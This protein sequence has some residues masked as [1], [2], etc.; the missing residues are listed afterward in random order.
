MV[1]DG[2]IELTE[3]DGAMRIRAIRST[4]GH[5]RVVVPD[6][7][8]TGQNLELIENGQIEA[9]RWAELL[10]G[11]DI[12]TALTSTIIAGETLTIRGDHENVDPGLGTT[13]D[14]QGAIGGS[15]AEITGESDDDVISLLNILEGT[16]TTVQTFNGDDT[17]NVGVTSFAEPSVDG[18]L[19]A[20]QGELWVDAGGGANMLNVTDRTNSYGR[21]EVVITN[22]RIAGFAPVPIHFSATGTFGRGINI[23][24]GAGDDGFQI[25]RT[26]SDSIT[27]IF[28]GAGD[29]GFVVGTLVPSVDG[30]LAMFGELGSDNVD[31]SASSL[32]VM[33]V[34]DHGY[35]LFHVD[36][37]NATALDEI[38]TV[39]AADGS[40]DR[41][42]GGSGNDILMGGEAGDTLSSGA[43]HDIVLGDLGIVK[44][45]SQSV[46]TEVETSSPGEG[47]D[48]DITVGNGLDVAFGGAGNDVIQAGQR[49]PNATD[50]FGGGVISVNFGSIF[51]GAEVRD[52]AG[53]VPA[54]NW[55]NIPT[56][57]LS[58]YGDDPGEAL[59]L[60]D[61][62]IAEG[63]TVEVGRDLDA[64]GPGV[65]GPLSV[66]SH[67]QINPV[68]DPNLRLF[69][70]YLFTDTLKTLGVNIAGL[71]AFTET[72]YDVYVYLDADEA[73]SS[74]STSV[75]RI[76]DGTTTYFLNDPQGNSFTG[77]FIPVD[78]T[79]P[80]SA[81][82][83]NYVVFRN[84]TSNAFALRID[85]QDVSNPANTWNRPAITALQ[86][87]DSTLDFE[88]QESDYRNVLVGDSGQATFAQG[89]LI[90]VITTDHPPQDDPLPQNDQI[91]GGEGPDIILGGNQ[92]DD[93][94]GRGGD[95]LILG[96]NARVALTYNSPSAVGD[97]VEID[98]LSW[99]NGGDDVLE[100]AAG[101]DRLYGQFGNDRYVFA[102]GQLGDDQVIEYGDG[103]GYPNDSH[104][105]LDFSEFDFPAIIDL[106]R[107]Q[108][109]IVALDN[110]HLTLIS[111]ATLEDVIGSPLADEILGNTRDNRLDGRGGN[112][113][114]KG[115]AGD[116]EIL[117]G[118]GDDIA[119]GGTGDDLLLGE[120]GDDTLAGEAGDDELHGGAG[121][122]QMSGGAGIDT[123]FGEFG[124][125][126]MDGGDDADALF[127]GPGDDVMFGGAGMDYAEGNEGDDHLHG[128]EEADIMFGGS[129]KDALFGGA[130]D[131]TLEGNEDDDILSGD[132]GM[133]T[134]L[135][136]SGNDLIEGG[137]ESD[138]LLGGPGNDTI[139]G[140]EGDDLI[141]GGTGDDSLRGDAG[142]DLLLGQEGR[143]T[144]RGN[145]G[146]DRIEGHA[147]DD[148]LE[149]NDGLD[150]IL[151]QDGHDVISGGADADFID[152][153]AGDDV[154]DGGEG[155]DQIVGNAGN[156]VLLGREGQD[157]LH[158]DAGHDEIDGG[159]GD[160]I[161]EG[162]DDSDVIRGGSGN[163][164]IRGGLGNDVIDGE[165]G[166][167]VIDGDEGD[168]VIT[169]GEGSDIIVG[170][171]GD[172]H[173]MLWATA[174]DSQTLIDG[175]DDNDT[176]TLG[177][178]TLNNF[179]GT[180][181]VDGGGGADRLELDDSTN[182]DETV[183][184]VTADSVSRNGLA[185]LVNYSAIETLTIAAGTQPDRFA[186]AASAETSYLLDGGQPTG[187]SGTTPG[188][189]LA[190]DLAGL[191]LVGNR[192][193]N[194]TAGTLEFETTSIVFEDF[195]SVEPPFADVAPTV[196][197]PIANQTAIV[198][199]PFSFTLPSNTFSDPNGDPLT[200]S[201]Q[202]LPSWLDFDTAT[203]TFSG[204]PTSPTES[205]ITVR[206]VAM[207]DDGN[208]G[209]AEFNLTASAPNPGNRAPIVVQPIADFTAAVGADEQVIDLSQVF[210][211]LDGDDL[212]FST[213]SS[214]TQCI[215]PSTSGSDLILSYQPNQHAR[216]TITVTATD[217]SN[218]SVSEAF[219]VTVGHV[220]D[221]LVIDMGQQEG[222]VV[223]SL[224]DLELLAMVGST[225]ILRWPTEDIEMVT[226]NRPA[227]D[228]DNVVF[229]GNWRTVGTS[230]VNGSF[231]RVL[232]QG[233]TE[234]PFSGPM[235]WQ[236]PVAPLDVN[237]DGNVTPA[238]ALFVIDQ[239][240]SPTVIRS[241]GQLVDAATLDPFPMQ[242]YD[243]NGDGRVLPIDALLII[244][245]LSKVD[246]PEGEM[247]AQVAIPLPPIAVFSSQPV[248]NATH[249]A[250]LT[251]DDRDR[252][253]PAVPVDCYS[254]DPEDALFTGT[255]LAC[256][257]VSRPGV[258]DSNEELESILEDIEADI[259]QEWERW[260]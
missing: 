214:S 28:A 36:A 88:L 222:D 255:G 179:A 61:G 75:R 126:T 191:P 170:G 70:G 74:G 67:D 158:G 161:A 21:S 3:Y 108:R 92:T 6:M 240:N 122:D 47:G 250:S 257:L 167:D 253:E 226:V 184:A 148:L 62:T 182:S 34:G 218:A 211:D 202:G 1:S 151:G 33:M 30:Y 8:A 107:A 194:V 210:A 115:L 187:Q 124:N 174:A 118:E 219:T 142:D 4:A 104:D 98:L 203:R 54:A 89:R 177:N 145:A 14:L 23:W 168:D 244:H 49:P 217:P 260:P 153:G 166:D 235:D 133:D 114:L 134:I 136:G 86:I 13:I 79:D 55:N 105:T 140:N 19:D 243:V 256:E 81:G 103:L 248:S 111:G 183:Y 252:H 130:G 101:D 241:N 186:V 220:K 242:F 227:G 69:E 97:V 58:I 138:T 22:D 7:V 57:A 11:D 236:N 45:N 212:T 215:Y 185:P 95:D 125:D 239:L 141:D 5:A 204:T 232:R 60:N 181:H 110:L 71:D 246:V 199:S 90:E 46:V 169:G 173:V 82:L 32:G 193:Q 68:L 198:G 230:I 162:G 15:S 91:I 192:P 208:I 96:D 147:G 99:Y 20:I 93:L 35:V 224:P 17:I 39:S 40:P 175:G 238:D 150:I 189:I 56:G 109:Q 196:V 201:V 24:S 128:N 31:A 163:D 258:N 216:V 149:G 157:S 123:V 53:V 117:G 100:G 38:A 205:P 113:F 164:G 176:I 42:L 188:D 87:V 155:D 197:N 50:P 83:G 77:R 228:P 180:V 234:L 209:I 213:T 171:S 10:V 137:D 225:E 259:H 106:A 223:V 229:S 127:G 195:E 247:T 76:T 112:D 254:G 237:A 221:S 26:R 165:S 116:D 16:P 152:G 12:A 59:L 9:A 233:T 63:V 146:D 64:I 190:V 84:I 102:G 143:D 51:P 160:D 131:D 25:T 66:D 43:G 178:G 72:G 48:D 78:A 135:G 80:A 65:P 231:C 29:D 144:I 154:M 73:K 44:F 37:D 156:D 139:M 132:G 94:Q 2:D 41:L 119:L 85:D 206:V 207:D 121:D 249:L 129:G 251:D 18:T 27:N 52:V 245:H 172:D 120:D 200:Y 159:P